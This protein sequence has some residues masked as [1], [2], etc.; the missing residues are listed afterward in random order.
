MNWKEFFRF[1]KCKLIIIGIFILI[2]VIGTYG[3]I[4]LKC[5]QKCPPTGCPEFPLS[6]K[7]G[8]AI[9]SSV[10]IIF[11]WPFFLIAGFIE[12]EIISLSVTLLVNLIYIYSLICLICFLIRKIKGKNA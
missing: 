3:L 11:T 9:A 2:I 5:I 10:F 8:C 4:D 7:I 1:D 6:H 12:N